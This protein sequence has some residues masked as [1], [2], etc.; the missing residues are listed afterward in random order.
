[1]ESGAKETDPSDVALATNQTTCPINAL[2]GEVESW[3]GDLSGN[4]TYQ[5]LRGV[6]QLYDVNCPNDF[7]PESG[8]RRSHHREHY[9]Y[10]SQ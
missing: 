4:V 6:S 3:Y 8:A 10:S 7:T 5:D 2:P 9:C 1:M